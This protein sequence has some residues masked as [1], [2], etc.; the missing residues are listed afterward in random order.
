MTGVRVDQ[1]MFVMPQ[2]HGRKTAPML[3][4][5]PRLIALPAKNPRRG[6]AKT[7]S[8]SLLRFTLS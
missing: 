6:S 4:P 8:T 2:P 3:M 5:N 1:P 7:A